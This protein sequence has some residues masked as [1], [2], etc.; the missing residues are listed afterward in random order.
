MHVKFIWDA[1][2]SFFH[3]LIYISRFKHNVVFVKPIKSIFMQ[4]W[5]TIRFVKDADIYQN[6]YVWFNHDFVE[7]V[8]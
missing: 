3:P 1:K 5:N 7:I 6:T 4:T 2:I 8:K